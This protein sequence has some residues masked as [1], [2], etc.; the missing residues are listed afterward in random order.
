MRFP[1][2]DWASSFAR[3]FAGVVMIEAEKQIYVGTPAL[4]LTRT[5][6][7]R[8]LPVADVVAARVVA[9]VERPVLDRGRGRSAR[10]VPLPRAPRRRH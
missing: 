5:G 1:S 6:S 10:V 4:A 2:S 9:A 8:Y 3:K 7:R